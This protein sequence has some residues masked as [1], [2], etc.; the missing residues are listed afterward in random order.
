MLNWETGVAVGE[1]VAD[2]V[3]S[4]RWDCDLY[5]E[6]EGLRREDMLLPEST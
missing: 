2:A 1:G 6:L 5:P 3:V 4:E